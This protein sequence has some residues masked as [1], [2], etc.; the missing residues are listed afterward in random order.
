MNIV[1]DIII[2][3]TIALSIFLGYKKGLIGVIL[4]ILSFFIALILAFMLY[5][6]VSTYI[7]NNTEIDDKIQISIEE[8]LSSSDI[9]NMANDK[10]EE[11]G[12]ELQAQTNMPS[13]ITD[14]IGAQVKNAAESAQDEVAKVVARN[15]TSTII[16]G[17]SLIGIFLVTKVIL[18]FLKIF[19][20]AIAK[21]PLI[22]QVNKAGG[23]MYG[24]LRGFFVVYLALAIISLISPMI[25]KTP[26]LTEIDNSMLG[27]AMYNNN[28]ILKMFFK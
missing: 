28:L 4:K 3:A 26:L 21:I 6:P 8:A 16:H 15:V 10:I 1:V 18:M 2:V 17:I 27:S 9:E 24:V 13:V 11:G 23:I 14:Y 7:I 12:E 22:K 25:T 5:K 19:A 20:D